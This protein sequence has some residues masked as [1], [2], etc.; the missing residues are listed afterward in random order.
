MDIR[1]ERTRKMLCEALEE[2]L[3]SKKIDEISVSEICAKS[4]VR[5]ATFYR[6]F[7]DKN[8]FFRYYLTTITDRFLDGLDTREDVDDLENYANEMQGELIEF[9]DSHENIMRYNVGTGA[10]A[11]TL[12]MMMEQIAVG[13]EERIRIFAKKKNTTLQS[14]P[15]FLARYY[16]G[17]MLHTLRWWYRE[18]K[19]IPA[20]ELIAQ[21]TTCLMSIVKSDCHS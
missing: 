12:D 18:N 16:A 2:L 4:T 14:E 6:H 17:G 19:P 21:S 10:F 11:G 9:L 1:S 15:G 20:D 3:G 5:R 13:I 7:E 8:D